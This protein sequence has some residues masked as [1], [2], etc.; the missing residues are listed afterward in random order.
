MNRLVLKN[1]VYYDEEKLSMDL[2]SNYVNITWGQYTRAPPE[3][4]YNRNCSRIRQH[5]VAV[6]T[7]D[8]RGRRLTQ[9]TL[10]RVRR[11]RSNYL[12]VMRNKRRRNRDNN[13]SSSSR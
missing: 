6:Q 4:I 2:V 9:T 7:N 10:G 3:V 8:A 11:G 13:N 5:E 1:D 12:K